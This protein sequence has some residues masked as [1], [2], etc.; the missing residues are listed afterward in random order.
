MND[1]LYTDSAVLEYKNLNSKG[2]IKIFEL[3]S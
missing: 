3:N 1:A 2:S